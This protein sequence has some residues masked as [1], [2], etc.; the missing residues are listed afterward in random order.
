MKAYCSS[1]KS[2]FHYLIDSTSENNFSSYF[3]KS[4]HFIIP[5]YVHI[6]TVLGSDGHL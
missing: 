3:Q 4:A 5:K 6:L 2:L 1:P